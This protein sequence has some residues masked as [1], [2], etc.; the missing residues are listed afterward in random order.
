[1][2]KDILVAVLVSLACVIACDAQSVLTRT[3]TNWGEPVHGVQISI[4]T[5]TNTFAVGSV[6][7]VIAQIKNVSTNAVFVKETSSRK[8]FTIWLE[9]GSGTKILLTDNSKSV[10]EFRNFTKEIRPGDINEWAIR[11]TVNGEVKPSNYSL[12]ATRKIWLS[13]QAF[14]VKS[15]PLEVQIE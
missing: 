2:K 6:F 10:I 9:N 13:G 4:E 3:N 5:T 7:T 11:L 1:M 14:I 12:K 8:D 15:N